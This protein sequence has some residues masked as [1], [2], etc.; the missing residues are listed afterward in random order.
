MKQIAILISSLAIL[1]MASCAP[2]GSE[3][4]S[5]RPGGTD[6]E[7]VSSSSPELPDGSISSSLPSSEHISEPTDFRNETILHCW[8]WSLDE[9][10]RNLE[11]IKEQGFT[12]VQT[13]PMQPQKDYYPNG[14]WQNEWWKLY[15]PLGFSI[16]ERDHSLGSKDDL[17]ELSNKADEL[18]IKLIVDVVSNHLAGGGS[19]SF[20]G[21]V[22][23]YEP[24]IYDANLLHKGVGSVDDHDVKRL[25]KGYLGGYPDLQTESKTVQ[26]AV[27]DLLEEYID[28][29]VDGFRFDAAKHIE[30][31]HDGEYASDYW[32]N[33]IGSAKEYASRKGK[34]LFVYGEILNTPGDGR[35]VAWYLEN[36][37]ITDT[38]ASWN[39]L[40]AATGNDLESVAKDDI[41]GYEID[42]DEAVLWGES[43]DTFANEGWGTRDA[44]QSDVDL[45]YAMAT[46][47]GDV[48]TLYF[49][50]P[51]DNGKM[52]E[53]GT[54]AY[55]EKPV[56]AINGFRL[57]MGDSSNSFSVDGDIMANE[58]ENGGTK[59]LAIFKKDGGSFSIATDLPNGNYVDEVTGSSFAALNGALTGEMDQS[60][61]AVVYAEGSGAST[62][63]PSISVSPSD[64]PIYDQP[65]QVTIDVRNA[66]ASSYSIDGGTPVSFD[67]TAA[68]SIGNGLPSETS[69]VVEATNGNGTSKKEMHYRF[70]EKTEMR[71]RV[72]DIPSEYIEGRELRAW[73]W[74]DG[75]ERFAEGELAGNSFSFAYEEG[76]RN[77]LL[78]TFKDDETEFSWNTCLEQTSDQTIEEGKVYDGVSLGWRK[79]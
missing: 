47:R 27:I 57:A 54:G 30:T 67:G 51:N 21:A 46:S 1:S 15:Q 76:D 39:L 19:E 72:D 26:N 65:I 71:I 74:G 61:I 68:V 10:S 3:S 23:H 6:S 2:T 33:V 48:S 69:L 36:M 60:G 78:A 18:G 24:E 64:S 22:R 32:D 70:A 28:C 13:S 14:N 11:T 38:V 9:I 29:G 5:H 37:D 58:R 63:L 16:A 45:A 79:V 55:K 35:D 31:S 73:V 49:A 12:A 75:R 53:S 34:D 43:H 62:A 44:K 52:G 4:S 41:F 25:V 17:I 56:A 7:S 77:F 20:N 42:K 59:G 40:N 8:N 66:D 50:R